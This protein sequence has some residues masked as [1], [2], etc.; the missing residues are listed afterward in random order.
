[1]CGDGGRGAAE[2]AEIINDLSGNDNDRPEGRPAGR[3]YSG[4]WSPAA[5][6]GIVH[7]RIQIGGDCRAS[8]GQDP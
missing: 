6:I 2:F 1:M 7:C 3:P 8:I 4:E 5:V